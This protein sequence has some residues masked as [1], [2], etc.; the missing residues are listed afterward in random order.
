MIQTI[1]ALIYTYESDFLT[2]IPIKTSHRKH[3]TFKNTVTN[4]IDFFDNNISIIKVFRRNKT[5][6]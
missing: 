3:I 4:N 1:G 2:N 5:P 6:S